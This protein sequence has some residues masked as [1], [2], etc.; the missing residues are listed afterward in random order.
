MLLRLI[1]TVLM[2]VGIS[3]CAPITPTST[4]ANQ[5]SQSNQ[6]DQGIQAAWVELGEQGKPIARVITKDLVCPMLYQDEH[7]EPMQTRAAPSRPALRSTASKPEE[8]KPSDFPVLVCEANLRP[9]LHRLRVANRDLPIPKS[10]I[11]KIVVIGDTGCRLQSSSKYFQPCNNGAGWA[12]QSVAQAAASFQ[13][14]LVIHVGDYHY[15]E[16]ACPAGQISCQNSPWGYGWDTW[17]ADFFTPAKVLLQAAPWVVVRGNH[18]SCRRGGQGWWR[19]LDPRP[20]HAEQSCDLAQ[21]DQLG[22]FSAPYA[23]PLNPN[24]QAGQQSAQ[25][26]IFDSSHVPNIALKKEDPAHAIYTAQFKQV[27]QLA[28]AADFNLFINHHPI[29]GFAPYPNKDNHTNYS[30][31]NL[32][33]QDVMRQDH[34]QRFFSDKIQTT[35]AGHV[36]VFEALSFASD[37]PSQFV[38]GNGGSSLDET[39]PTQL[40]A[41]VTPAVGAKL[42]YFNNSNEVGYMTLERV[43]NIWD[44]HAWNSLGKVIEHCQIKQQVTTCNALHP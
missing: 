34:P 26:I 10:N 31:G 5:S 13:P 2:I 15:R 16:N 43:G 25:L 24:A 3:A 14:D 21:F 8:S 11:Q 12:F 42:A 17:Q 38:S 33:L 30:Y 9:A 6:A 28:N 44:I 1:L 39:L 23:V 20:F 7:A 19:F 29:L 4:S 37:H 40:P 32:A 27:D 35:I 41:G 22:D 18:E 36:H